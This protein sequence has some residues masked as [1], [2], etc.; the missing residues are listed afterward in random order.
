MMGN[1]PVRM[2]TLHAWLPRLMAPRAVQWCKLRRLPSV[3]RQL[4]LSSPRSIMSTGPSTSTSHSNFLP[5][6][7][8]AL[9]SYRRKTKKDLAKHPLLS[10]LQSCDSPDAVL[11]VLRDQIPAFNQ[12]QNRDD[13]LTKWVIPTVNVLYTFSATVGKGVGLV[14]IMIFCRQECLL[15]FIFSGFPTCKCNFC[16][17]RCPSFRPCHA[18]LPGTTDFDNTPRR[19]KMSALAETSSSTS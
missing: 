4:S 3:R 5:I 9:E 16:G 11:T 7:N 18:S 1:M 6:F 14:N 13:E 10:T 12:S 17:N 19:L 2:P 15:I 8:S